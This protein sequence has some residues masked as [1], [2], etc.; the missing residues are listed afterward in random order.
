M[1]WKQE[2][3]GRWRHDSCSMLK[4]SVTH[5]WRI[6]W[7]ADEMVISYKVILMVLCYDAF[8]LNMNVW[9]QLWGICC[10]HC[11]KVFC[12]GKH[13]KCHYEGYWT[14]WVHAGIFYTHPTPDSIPTKRFANKRELTPLPKDNNPEHDLEKPSIF[15]AVYS[16]RPKWCK[17][18]KKTYYSGQHHSLRFFKCTLWKLRSWGVIPLRFFT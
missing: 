4:P 12:F 15:H 3:C 14:F 16:Q 11:W 8:L 9:L 6:N 5:S 18:K 1:T 17:L 10:K 13:S 7:N 2:N